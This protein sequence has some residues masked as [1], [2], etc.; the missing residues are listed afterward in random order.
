[1]AVALDTFRNSGDPSNSF[2]GIATGHGSAV[3][4]LT[5]AGTTVVPTRL[6]QGPQRVE[7]TVLGERILV[8]L[9]GTPRL[10][11]P[12][13]VPA[14]A[15]LAFTAGTGGLTNRHAVRDV[16]ITA[17][18]WLPSPTGAGWSING[19]ARS[20]GLDLV[21]TPALQ[22]LAGSAFAVTP[23]DTSGGVHVR[24]TAAIGGGSGADGLALALI[25]AATAQ[26]TAVGHAGG[27][28]GFVG[29]PGIAV[30]A[31]TFH[32]TGDPSNNFVA[33]ATGGNADQPSYAGTSTAIGD[34]RSGTH[35]IDAVFTAGRV[36]VSVDGSQV[37]DA[38]ATPPAQALIGFTAGTGGLTDRHV[39]RDVTIA[40]V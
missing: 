17:G 33:V 15:L 16:T 35:L 1:V 40:R 6:D 30:T 36:R 12:A 4:S 27:G 10:D 38:P 34:L 14:T 9:N 21:L 13:G 29:L 3:D 39:V 26:P 20:A 37:I 25:D 22:N 2:L 24:F 8:A 23:I 31:D 11:V 28:L 32:N 18:G 7:V 5:W 19:A